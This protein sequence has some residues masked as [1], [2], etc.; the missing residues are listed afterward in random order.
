MRFLN[1]YSIITA[2]KDVQ[3]H[4]EISREKNGGLTQE[5]FNALLRKVDG[6]RA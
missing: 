2:I 4:T 5:S 6:I 3:S 1:D